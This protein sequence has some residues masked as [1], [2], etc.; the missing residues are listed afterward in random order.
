MYCNIFTH[1]FCSFPHPKLSLLFCLYF[2]KGF[3]EKYLIKDCT[4]LDKI[5]EGAS[6]DIY[7]IK[8]N[9]EDVAAKQFKKSLSRKKM[10]SVANQL[11]KLK[12]P[13][14]VKF[15]GF[16]IKPSTIFLEFCSISIGEEHFNNISQ[17]IG[18]WNEEENFNFQQRIALLCQ[19]AT[20]VSYLHGQ[21]IVHK[22]IK[23]S[24]LLVTRGT[25]GKI[26]VK[27]SDFDAVLALK[28]AVTSTMTKVSSNVGVTIGYTAPEICAGNVS[29]VSKETD[30]F[31]LA[32]TLFEI[33]DSTSSAW[34]GVLPLM[35][36]SLL[37]KMICDGKRPL[38]S[39][40]ETI[41]GS[42]VAE[43]KINSLISDMW[44]H[45]PAD[46]PETDQVSA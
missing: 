5:D 44:N 22:D 40:I 11:S 38:L 21:H 42:N 45:C 35:N 32:I 31:A 4:Y 3:E 18:Y 9:D 43:V 39:R 36:D 34:N 19:V 30:I 2:R 37:M 27:I 33:L 14:I 28:E 41:Y 6:A 46:R 13:N 16:S 12:H 15:H 23:P 29:N 20:G 17:L 8:L 1:R 7:K 24:N 10:T 26:L 25:I